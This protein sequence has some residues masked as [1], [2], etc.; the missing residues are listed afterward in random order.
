VIKAWYIEIDKTVGKL[1][2]LLDEDTYTLIMSDHGAGP[3]YHILFINEWLKKHGFL[4]LKSENSRNLVEVTSYVLSWLKNFMFKYLSTPL[5]RKILPFIPKRLLLRVSHRG[6]IKQDIDRVLKR[7]D[8]SQSIAFAF[9]GLSPNGR[10]HINVR[11]S[12]VRKKYREIR[13]EIIEKLQQMSLELGGDVRIDIHTKE[14]VYWGEHSDIAPDI[15]FY[16]FVNGIPCETSPEIGCGTLLGRHPISGGHV[17]EGFWALVGP[18]VKKNKKINAKIIDLAPT[19]LHLL[20]MPVLSDMDG[21]VIENAFEQIGAVR[22]AEP[23]TLSREEF[24]YSEKEKEE[25]RMRL[26]R[27]GYI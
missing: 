27:L 13:D 14:E 11:R 7:I 5:I 10:I 18:N 24:A 25:I 3:L 19:I 4:K 26:K 9:G 17:K 8:W 23:L 12:E 16:L 2:K 1:M 21:Q 6:S 20:G 15:I 22:F